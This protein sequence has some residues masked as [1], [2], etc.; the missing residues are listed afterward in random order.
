M[1][2]HNEDESIDLRSTVHGPTYV[3]F[4]VHAVRPKR[5]TNQTIVPSRGEPSFESVHVGR[6]FGFDPAIHLKG[7]AEQVIVPPKGKQI[8][9]RDFAMVDDDATPLFFGD[10]NFDDGLIFLEP[11]VT[12]SAPV[13]F[14][15]RSP[16]PNE[17]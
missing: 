8:L 3:R 11:E 13:F 1:V 2:L 15:E 4:L 5:E 16:N 12:R 6:C 17:L 7:E 9:E 10:W 14:W